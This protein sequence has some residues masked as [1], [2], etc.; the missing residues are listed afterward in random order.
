MPTITISCP[1]CGFAKDTLKAR[2]PANDVQVTCPQCKQ[3]FALSLIKSPSKPSGAG[4]AVP[5][6][7]A[8]SLS[9]AFMNANPAMLSEARLFYVKMQLRI[10]MSITPVAMLFMPFILPFKFSQL[11]TQGAVV[12]ASLYLVTLALTVYLV[13]RHWQPALILTERGLEYTLSNPFKPVFLA[14]NQIHGITIDERTVYGNTQSMA[15]LVLAPDSKGVTEVVIGL[16]ALENSDEALVLLKQLIPEKNT[17]DFADTLLRYKPVSTDTLRYRDIKLVR[18][19]IIPEAGKR[20][21]VPWDCIDSI[22]TEGLV[23][24]G[25]GS[26]TVQFHDKGITKRLLIRSSTKETYHECIKLL[27]TKAN[28]ATLDPA[29]LAIL[30]YPVT[31]AKAD[32]VAILLV[33]TGVIVGIAAMLLLS[34]YPPTVASTWIFPLLLCG[35]FCLDHQ[36]VD[37]QVQGWWRRSVQKDTWRLVVQHWYR[38]FD[39]D[40]L[41]AVAGIVHLDAC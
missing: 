23:I 4:N 25:Y 17:R 16:T 5:S 26:V 29:V 30:E 39:S 15:R 6:A 13:W 18:E 37:Q 38:H 21:V 34:F 12:L 11:P 33:C 22:K 8:G 35:P 40:P 20:A 36:A 32:I 41:Y 14:W 2:V 28:N 3:R 27:I 1:H 24:A 31:S 7:T 19:G 9:V 10:L